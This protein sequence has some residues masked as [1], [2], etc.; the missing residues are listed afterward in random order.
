MPGRKVGAGVRGPQQPC[1]P[2]QVSNIL[3]EPEHIGQV[4]LLTGKPRS[5]ETAKG[6]TEGIVVGENK[7]LPTLQDEVEVM[8]GSLD[9][10]QVSVESCSG[11]RQ[12]SASWRRRRVWPRTSSENFVEQPR[13]WCWRG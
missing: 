12:M 8:N 3:H 13:C 4:P 6:M 9:G 7:E 10:Q 5:R 11:T 1:C 2:H